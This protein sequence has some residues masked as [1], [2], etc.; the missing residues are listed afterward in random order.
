MM[1]RIKHFI[2]LIFF[3]AAIQNIEAETNAD[4]II[5]NWISPKKDV[6]IK[7]F[8]YNNKYFGKIVWFKRYYD[9]APDDPKMLPE[10]KWL[11]TVVMKNFTYKNNEWSDGK[12]FQV[13]TCKTYDAYIKLN[14]FNSLQLTGYVCLR[15]FCET[16]SFSRYTEVEFPKD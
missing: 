9:D 6:I 2:L 16:V 4:K 3:C 14:N 1:F 13:K 8:K 11:N 10:S 15:F 12:I 7:C 5:G